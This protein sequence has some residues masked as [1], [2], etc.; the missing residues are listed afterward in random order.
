MAGPASAH[1]GAI[2][3]ALEILLSLQVLTDDPPYL[4]RHFWDHFAYVRTIV[5]W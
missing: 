3:E 5:R 1:P 2:E 4:L